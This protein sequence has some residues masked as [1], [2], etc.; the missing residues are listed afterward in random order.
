MVEGKYTL[1]YIPRFEADLNNIVDYL[2]PRP[3]K[4]QAASF[5]YPQGTWNAAACCNENRNAVRFGPRSWI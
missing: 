4:A 2:P 3:I 1:R 5:F